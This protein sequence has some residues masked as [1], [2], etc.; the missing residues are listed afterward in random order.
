VSEMSDYEIA[1][2]LAS[3]VRT[4]S[5]GLKPE[6]ELTLRFGAVFQAMTLKC[7]SMRVRRPLFLFGCDSL[8]FL[9]SSKFERVTPKTPEIDKYGNA[10]IEFSPA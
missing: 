6:S 5:R 3:V 1:S 8:F 9:F 2:S 4:F 10:I 7:A